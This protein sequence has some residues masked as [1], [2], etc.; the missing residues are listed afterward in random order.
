MFVRCAAFC[1]TAL[2]IGLP[3]TADEV[4]STPRGEAYYAEEMDGFA[5][6]RLPW[7]EIEATLYFEG[8]AGNYDNRDIHDGYWIA[9]GAGDCTAALVGIDDQISTDWGRVTLVF[10]R[11][12]FPT[13]WTAI[14]TTC[15][16]DD[17]FTI[18]GDLLQ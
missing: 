3:A 14:F 7:G 5:I 12:S 9:P 1:I 15:F 2:T 10:D 6:F 17:P 16:N 13:G 11:P 8:L 4:W 18:R